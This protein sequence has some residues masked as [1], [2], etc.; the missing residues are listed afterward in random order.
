MSLWEWSVCDFFLDRE[1]YDCLPV[2]FGIYYFLFY[3]A[4]FKHRFCYG[5][6]DAE[7]FTGTSHYFN[8]IV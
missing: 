7:L 5:T 2:E 3:A 4:T 1:F 6:H 8:G